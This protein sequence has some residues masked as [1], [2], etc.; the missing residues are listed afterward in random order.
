[1]TM[2]FIAGN[3]AQLNSKVVPL[4]LPRFRVNLSI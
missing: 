3:A 1:M 4:L 2:L